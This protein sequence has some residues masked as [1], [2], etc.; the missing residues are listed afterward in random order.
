MYV[1]DVRCTAKVDVFCR[2]QKEVKQMF[3]K[4]GFDLIDGTDSRGFGKDDIII[5][6]SKQGKSIED[7]FDV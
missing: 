7:C 5:D 4:K 6:I 3:A 1:D 2:Y